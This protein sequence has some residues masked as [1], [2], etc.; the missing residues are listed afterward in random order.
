[1]L[2]LLS[3]ALRAGVRVNFRALLQALRGP[4]GQING[5]I[6]LVEFV[7]G[8]R[9]T[10]VN[11]HQDLHGSMEVRSTTL[12]HVCLL[13]FIYSTETARSLAPT[14]HPARHLWQH[15]YPQWQLP[16]APPQAGRPQPHAVSHYTQCHLSNHKQLVRHIPGNQVVMG[17]RV[18]LQS[19]QFTSSRWL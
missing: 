15:P 3:A 2:S 8:A 14:Q 11:I 7:G 18:N 9:P 13:S 12:L 16:V 19:A 5:M 17:L 1:M 10:P 4:G 6:P